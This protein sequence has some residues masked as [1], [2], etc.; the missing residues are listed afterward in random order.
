MDWNETRSTARDNHRTLFFNLYVNNLANFMS[1]TAHIL[2]YADNCFNFCSGEESEIANE[3]LQD[4]LFKL[5]E[6]FCLQKLN[7][8]ESK[9]EFITFSLKNAKRLR[10]SYCRLHHSEEVRPLRIH[11]CNH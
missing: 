9:T 10:H 8:N 6:Y 2:Q 4:N 11:K 5:E 3:V 7:L 1:E